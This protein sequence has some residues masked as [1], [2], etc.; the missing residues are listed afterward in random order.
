M[1]RYLSNMLAAA[2]LLAAAAGTAHAACGDLNSSGGIDP[3][4][5][6]ILANELGGAS[7]VCDTTPA[8]CDLDGSGQPAPV[9]VT[10]IGV[11]DIVFML[12]LLATYQEPETVSRVSGIPTGWQRSDYNVRARAAHRI[13]D[14]VERID[15][16]YLVV[17]F[18]DEGFVPPAEMRAMLGDAGAVTGHAIP[19]NAFRGSRNLSGRAV[20]V[21][22][23][24]FVVKK[25]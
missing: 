20:H 23:H 15:A 25:W 14:L 17:S 24:L 1:K 19:Y 6:V 2:L 21:T 3:G 7:T 18:N 10:D 5:A 11:G 9:L 8:D 4:D 12:N 16:R 13:A 22:E